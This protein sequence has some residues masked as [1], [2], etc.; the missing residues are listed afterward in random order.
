[1]F[2]L[3]LLFK[4]NCETLKK[5]PIFCSTVCS[6]SQVHIAT[7]VFRTDAGP[8]WKTPQ[9]PRPSTWPLLRINKW[10]RLK[11]LENIHFIQSVI[12]A[13][14]QFAILMRQHRNLHHHHNFLRWCLLAGPLQGAR[15]GTIVVKNPEVFTW[16]TCHRRF[17]KENIMWHPQVLM[18][19]N[20]WKRNHLL[21]VPLLHSPAGGSR[22]V[23]APCHRSWQGGEEKFSA[24]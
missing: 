24:E 22:L 19:P 9:T 4:L 15:S 20:S 16:W 1:M 11:K 13:A 23:T 12:G 6:C 10:T 2:D 5:K 8:P 7:S 21:Q 18:F 17:E 3:T 14:L